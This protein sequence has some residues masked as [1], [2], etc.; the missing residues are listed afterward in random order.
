MSKITLKKLAAIVS[1]KFIEHKLDC[2]LVG[3]AC[4]SIYSKN[5]YQSYD[6]D[7]VTYEDMR[8]IEK[9][10]SELGFNRKQRY[11]YHPDCPFFIEFV[12]PPVSIGSEPVNTYNYLGEIK[13][14]TPTDCVKD[15]LA[16]YFFWDDRQ[17][18]DQAII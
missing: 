11:F 15:R 3:G 18:L 13:L 2:I 17:A 6:L 7:Y 9:A 5:R 16:C 1:E 8:L 10:L 12:A 14:L 4:V